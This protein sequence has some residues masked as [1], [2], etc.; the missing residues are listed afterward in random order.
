[1]RDEW[2]LSGAAEPPRLPAQAPQNPFRA[3]CECGLRHLQGPHPHAARRG[4]DREL[5]ESAEHARGFLPA[6]CA[7]RHR[8]PGVSK[9]RRGRGAFFENPRRDRDHG[10]RLG[11]HSARS[12]RRE[13]F[14]AR[15]DRIH[16]ARTRHP[17]P[18]PV[19]HGPPARAGIQ[20]GRTP[21]FQGPRKHHLC[22]R[23]P[24]ASA[25]PRGEPRL[26]QPLRDPRLSREPPQRAARQAMAGHAGRRPARTRRGGIRP[27]NRAAA[28]FLLAAASG[29]CRG[30]RNEGPRNSPPPTP[31]PAP[32]KK[33]EA[34][35]C[36]GRA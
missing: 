5:E 27:R 12:R 30:F 21:D 13:R 36:G 35:S 19:A 2:C 8:G 7:R 10:P 22:L 11:I 31:R 23:G 26:R 4:I 15:R 28:G 24:P 25:R 14:H 9:S 32:A 17:H 20:Q 1:M 6:R 33:S 18:L 34:R 29:P 3:V 16:P